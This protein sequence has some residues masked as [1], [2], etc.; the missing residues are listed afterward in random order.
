MSNCKDIFFVVWDWLTQPLSG[1]HVETRE[2]KSRKIRI[3]MTHDSTPDT[4]AC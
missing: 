1:A 3:T 2:H 4:L